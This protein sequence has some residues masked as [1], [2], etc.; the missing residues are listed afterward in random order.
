MVPA[1]KA[2][3]ILDFIACGDYPVDASY[4]MPRRLATAAVSCSAS[5]DVCGAH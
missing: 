3:T 1:C 5:Y 2:N 4:A